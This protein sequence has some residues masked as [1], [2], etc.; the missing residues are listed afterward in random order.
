MLFYNFFLG[1]R[2]TLR[3]FRFL[4]PYIPQGKEQEKKTKKNRKN[5][6][7]QENAINHWVVKIKKLL[8]TI[9]KSY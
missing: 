1:L 4:K 2:I 9:K 8:K 5:A 6:K 7:R 3:D